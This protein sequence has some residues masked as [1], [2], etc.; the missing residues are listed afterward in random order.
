LRALSEGEVGEVLKV[1]A[2]ERRFQ[3]AL[4]ISDS[5]VSYQVG[6]RGVSAKVKAYRAEIDKV[7]KRIFHDCEDWRKLAESRRFCKHLVKL[8]LALP[9]EIAVD[10]LSEIVSNLEDW[11]FEG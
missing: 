1:L 11:S 3:R 4:E 7:E 2:G 8:F 6:D 5:D 10:L 9:R